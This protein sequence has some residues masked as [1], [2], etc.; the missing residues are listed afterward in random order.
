MQDLSI[1]GL[2]QVPAEMLVVSGNG[3]E[4]KIKPAQN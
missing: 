2:V 1:G 3:L 4:R